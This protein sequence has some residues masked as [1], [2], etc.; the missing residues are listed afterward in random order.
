[1][2]HIWSFE[3]DAARHAARERRW[4]DKEWIEDDLPQ[5]LPMIEAQE[6]KLMSAARF[7]SGPLTQLD[8]LAAKTE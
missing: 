7:F 3:E 1:M 8:G 2:R 5:A 4:Q 6:N